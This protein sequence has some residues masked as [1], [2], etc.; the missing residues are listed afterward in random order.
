[1]PLKPHPTDQDKM[2]YVKRE[3]ILPKEWV[4]LTEK[5]HTELAI[6]CGCLSID[7]V[8]YGEAVERKLKEKNI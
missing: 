7:W 3:Y 4:S 5:E 1:M 8:F 2:V 6:E